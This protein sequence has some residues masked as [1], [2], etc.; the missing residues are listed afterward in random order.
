MA[1]D[2]TEKGEVNE[3]NEKSGY[4]YKRV[5]EQA[6]PYIPMHMVS[7]THMHAYT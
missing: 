2:H 7:I 6:D 3:D 1:A 4:I 5:D